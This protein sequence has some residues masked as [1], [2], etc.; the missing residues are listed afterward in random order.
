M[1]TRKVSSDTSS[2][3]SGRIRCAKLSKLWSLQGGA[4]SKKSY[5]CGILIFSSSSMGV[6][7]LATWLE[8]C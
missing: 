6:C 4:S 2:S 7:A 8:A 5:V 1:P 3:G